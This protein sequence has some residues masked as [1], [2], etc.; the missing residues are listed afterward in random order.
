MCDSIYFDT[1]VSQGE[2]CLIFHLC[3]FFSFFHSTTFVFDFLILFD[4]H[5]ISS[6]FLFGNL[7][8]GR[9]G[10]WIDG[11]GVYTDL[12]E[13][14]ERAMRETRERKGVGVGKKEHSTGFRPDRIDG[15]AVLSW[16]FT[17]HNGR[18]NRWP[19]FFF[20]FFSFFPSLFMRFFSFLGLAFSFCYFCYFYHWFVSVLTFTFSALLNYNEEICIEKKVTVPKKIV[21]ALCHRRANLSF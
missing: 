8:Q 17:V 4:F 2:L 7:Y 15:N 1:N 10:H 21:Q 5:F 16:G 6:C 18:E 13:I 20:F 14:N 11:S 19:C 9:E 12:V 3:L